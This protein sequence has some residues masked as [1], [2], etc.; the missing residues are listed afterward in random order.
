M[1]VTYINN[2]I[3]S[4]DIINRIAKN[5]NYDMIQNYS[6]PNYLLGKSAREIIKKQLPCFVDCQSCPKFGEC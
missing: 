1:N 5:I 3:Y 2:E 6:N 4:K